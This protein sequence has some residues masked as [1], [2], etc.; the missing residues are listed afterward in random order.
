MERTLRGNPPNPEE[1]RSEKKPKDLGSYF[2]WFTRKGKEYGGRTD[3][4]R[5]WEKFGGQL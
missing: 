3:D 2:I 1:D 4:L 5:M